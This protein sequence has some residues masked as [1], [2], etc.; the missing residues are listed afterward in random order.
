MKEATLDDNELVDA[1]AELI[2]GYRSID[3]IA[4]KLGL[5]RAKWIPV[6]YCFIKAEVV[7]VSTAQQ[8]S[9][10]DNKALI[11]FH[12]D[13][14]SM[15]GLIDVGTSLYTSATFL[16]LLQL[17]LTRSQVHRRPF[18]VILLLLKRDNSH[19]VE[20]Q[21]LLDSVERIR[22]VTRP[23]DLICHFE[24]SN[25]GI[26]L[27]D[28][29]KSEAKII[30]RRM[31]EQLALD[32]TTSVEVRKTLF[33]KIGGVTVPEDCNSIDELLLM[34]LDPDHSSVLRLWQH[35]WS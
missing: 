21:Y 2:D 22:T 23:S 1:I 14:I 4:W 13:Q 6:I 29:S 34:A 27:P 28:T 5:S 9:S 33:V 32:R 35:S 11:Q 8:A 24:D 17:E 30:A 18:S 19:P 25:L 16:F 12:A 7:Q 31:L 20:V 26:I 10:M 15:H 3:A